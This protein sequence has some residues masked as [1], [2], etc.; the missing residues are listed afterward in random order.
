MKQL[1][2]A[3]NTLARN[4][5][6]LH[7]AVLILVLFV[8][9]VALT[10]PAWA[11]MATM[12]IRN[13]YARTSVLVLPIMAWLVWVRRARFRFV[14]P[15]GPGL[16]VIVLIS[17]IQ[18]YL[19]AEYYYGLRS[20][21]HFGAVAIVA[22]AFLI[23]TG[24]SVIRPFLPAWGILP[25]LVPVPVTVADLIAKPIQLFEAESIAALYG[26]LGVSVEVLNLPGAS[27][28]IVGETD[29]PIDV[30]CKGL[31]TI[32]SLILI[33]YGFV[34]G[35]PMRP[36]VRATLLIIAPIIALVCSSIAL[37]G[38]LWLYDGRS[39]LMTADLIRA[40]SEWATLLLAFLLI[41]GS[42][43]LLTWASVPVHQ[44]HLAS[45]ST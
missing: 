45:T 18:I 27:R 20:A 37:G 21:A 17:G 38:T 11:E 41:A 10:W 34:F 7:H 42:L 5:W 1:N 15:G 32:L 14:K 2:Q 8:L 36:V 31:P 13:D 44:Y 6:R 3:A 26:L 23:V 12:V 29:L 28:V 43:R 25:F 35:S 4:G 24:K 19:V 30:V 33:S 9:S 39:A 22:G 40:A 16:G